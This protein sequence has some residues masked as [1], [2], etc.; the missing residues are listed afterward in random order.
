M[1]AHADTATYPAGTSVGSLYRPGSPDQSVV[2]VGGNAIEG[3]DVDPTDNNHVVAVVAGFASGPNVPHVYESHDA[4]ATWTGLINGLPNMPVYSV[5]VHDANTII[6]GTEFGIW[7]WDGTSWHEENGGF[8]RVPV[9]RMIER[10]LYAGG[11]NVLYLGSHGRGMWRSTTLTPS[12]CRTSVG[13]G[14][15]NVKPNAING[16]SI[17]PNPVHNS[18]KVSFTIDNSAKVTL[19]VFD[20]TGK[21]HSEKTYQNVAA[22][23]NLFDL[24]ADGLSSGTYVL[25]ATLADERTMSKLFVVA[26]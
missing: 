21:L 5:V 1:N 11:C 14:V 13:T 10:P 6:I 9:Y 12:G 24:N 19:R 18:A 26:K 22:G 17:Y 23:T 7:S 16:L 4:G 3:I 25:A 15:N 8:E 20:M 2:Q